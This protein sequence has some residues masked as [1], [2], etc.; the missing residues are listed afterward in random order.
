M[1]KRNVEKKSK[2]G[3]YDDELTSKPLRSQLQG[4][5]VPMGPACLKCG[6]EIDARPGWS[7][8]DTKGTKKLARNGYMHVECEVE[9][10]IEAAVKRNVKATKIDKNGYLDVSA[11]GLKLEVPVYSDE[12]LATMVQPVGDLS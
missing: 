4:V 7:V 8:K 2:P 9:A 6:G 1:S 5:K 12:E 10:V 11:P 3:R